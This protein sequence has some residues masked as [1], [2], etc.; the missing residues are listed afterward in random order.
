MA[1]PMPFDLWWSPSMKR[2]LSR[3][4][5]S[6]DE[7]LVWVMQ[8]GSESLR[9]YLGTGLESNPPL[10][11]DAV[12]LVLA[13]PEQHTELEQLKAQ[14]AAW[15]KVQGEER[16]AVKRQRDALSLLLRGMA[17]KLVAYRKWMS[18]DDVPVVHRLRREAEE[19]Q[20]RIEALEKQVAVGHRMQLVVAAQWLNYAAEKIGNIPDV[21]YLEA[22]S[23]WLA[24]NT[25]GDEP[26]AT[27]G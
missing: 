27:S 10:P 12:Q 11:D 1:E 6:D 9:H 20:A 2:L 15:W 8:G 17:R 5:N 7:H 19:R 3:H 23:E 16:R 26:E 4:E 22:L 25:E 21:A 14:H 13:D 18:G 24:S